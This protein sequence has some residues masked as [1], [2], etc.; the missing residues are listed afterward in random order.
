MRFTGLVAKIVAI[1]VF[2]TCTVFMPSPER[3]NALVGWVGAAGSP[4]IGSVASQP[5]DINVSN[6][7]GTSYIPHIVVDTNGYPCISWVDYSAGNEEIFF[8]RWNGS[9][10]I[11]TQGALLNATNGNVSNTPGRSYE[12]H[13]VL[14]KNNYP[15]LVWED[16]SLG[17]WEIFFSRWDGFQWVNVQGLPVTNTNRNVSNNIG[18][19]NIP[20]LVLDSL[21]NPCISWSDT[22]PGNH[23]IYY[24][25]WNGSNWVNIHGTILSSM[26]ANISNNNGFSY[27]SNFYLDSQDYPLITWYDDTVGNWEIF[28]CKWNGVNWVNIQDTILNSTNGNISNNIGRSQHPCVA[29]NKLNY[30]CLAWEDETS[31]PGVDEIYY[32]CFNGINW[33][34]AQSQIYN[35]INANISNNAGRSHHPSLVL[36]TLDFPNI[37]WSDNTSGNFEVYYSRFNGNNWITIDGY[38][39]NN[40]NPNISNTTDWSY[41]PRFTL[42]TLDNPNIVWADLTPGV[43]EIYYTKFS[44]SFDGSFTITKSVDTN[45]DGDYSDS[46]KNVSAGDT[47]SY[48]INWKFNQGQDALENPYLYDTIPD[49]TTYVSGSASPTANIS[50]STD[51]GATWIAGEPPN[52]SPAGTRLRWDLS[53][54]WVGAAG[55]PYVG[56]AATQPLDINVSRDNGNSQVPIVKRNSKGYPNI[57]W[58]D[59]SSG[60]YEIYFCKWNGSQWVNA[61]G[62]TFTLANGN[63]SNTAFD[64][65]FPDFSL[66][67][68][69][70]PVVAW[71]ELSSNYEIFVARWNGWLWTN[72]QG[73]PLTA[74]NGNVSNSTG[75][76]N[77][78]DLRIDKNGF[79]HLC[80]WDT[81]PGNQDIYYAKWDGSNW[82]NASNMI[83]T[84]TNPNVSNNPGV[85]HYP[86]LVL[87]SNN[88]PTI[89]WDDTSAGNR[90]I[91]FTRWNGS[92]W[93][94][95]NGSTLTATNANI[96]NNT[97]NSW[98]AMCILGSNDNPY[99]TWQDDTPGN[100]EIYFAKWNGGNWVDQNNV[101]LNATNANISNNVGFSGYA[102]LCLDSSS[103]PYVMW[104]DNTLGNYDIFFQKWNGSAWV[105][106]D[107]LLNSIV[108]IDISNNSGISSSPRFYLD[109]N[110]NPEL[111]WHDDTLGNNE[112][113]FVMVENALSF[114]FSVKIDN[115]AT[116]YGI[117]NHATFRHKWD[118]DSA[119]ESNE[120]CNTIK[121]NYTGT[122]TLEK[123][124]D[125]NGDGKYT[126]NATTIAPGTTLGYKLDWTFDNPNNDPLNGAYIYDTVPLGTK[127]VTGSSPTF[128]LS[129]STD[130]GFSW[131]AGEPPDGSAAGTILRWKLTQPGWTNA[132]GQLVNSTN[133]NMS[134]NTGISDFPSLAVYKDGHPS[135]AWSDDVLGTTMVYYAKWNGTQWVNAA[136]LPFTAANGN[137]A[138]LAGGDPSLALDP[139]TG[140]PWIAFQSNGIVFTNLEIHVVKWNGSQWTNSA[141]MPATLVNSNISNNAGLSW[142]PSQLVLDSKGYP[143]IVWKDNTTGSFQNYFARWNGTNWTNAAGTILNTTNGSMGNNVV[144]SFWPTISLDPNDRP[145]VAWD[146]NFGTNFE[147]YFA[148]WDGTQWVTA[149][150]TPLTPTNGNISNNTGSSQIPFLFTDRVT[151]NPCIAWSD[152]TPGNYEIYFARWNGS[153]WVN[154]DS[155]AIDSTN[156]NM[157]HTSGGSYLLSLGLDF[158]NLPAISWEDDTTG[159][160]EIYYSKWSGSA[161]VNAK[162]D[163]FTAV[164]GIINTSPARSWFPSLAFDPVT[165]NPNI[166]WLDKTPGNNEVYFA[167][168][169]EHHQTF[170]FSVIVDKP[171]SVP[172]LSPICNS[173]TFSHAFD[174]GNPLSSNSVCVKVKGASEVK[175]ANLVIRKTAKSL[176]YNPKDTFVF[177]ITVA[178]NGSTAAENVVLTDNFPNELVFDSSTPSGQVGFSTVKFSLGTLAPNASASFTLKFK[179]S[180]K[181]TI[182]DCITVINEAIASSGTLIVKDTA[183]INICT[184]KAPCELYI[185]TKWTNVIKGVRAKGEPVKLEV[186]PRCG[187]SPYS[188]T[189]DWGDGSTNS[190]TVEGEGESYITGHTFADTGDFTV[191]ITCVDA[192]GSTRIVTKTLY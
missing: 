13:L 54:L 38:T 88:Y 18:D 105:S 24:S 139:L 103:N 75:T 95:A 121:F 65:G 61:G 132:Q 150:G 48:K 192:Y 39:I 77:D 143:C 93:V 68:S 148:K 17:N 117:C 126:D 66:D 58:Q 44:N 32:L 19:S 53:S 21:G 49:G 40:L 9:T 92:S 112:I 29:K 63:V 52:G 119:I 98:Y 170:T 127:Y 71:S 87:D 164:N 163:A 64:S 155:T 145:F 97:G 102:A 140:N 147:V 154:S 47:L 100:S 90:E 23:E 124:V 161:W 51:G 111:V 172:A 25:K 94:N 86:D 67:S 142:F 1:V 116:S 129:Y 109:S 151:G 152:D 135:I 15:C 162:G 85:S 20:V 130:N 179:L 10:W 123:G 189:I 5:M 50:Y 91:F 79:V 133:P 22:T 176:Q 191:K 69:D 72:M 183:A 141:G 134:K 160:S 34:N 33:V 157:S 187:S 35:G 37:T 169:T 178:N 190:G 30:P 84:A 136:G 115:P 120:V 83:L 74:T 171:F 78:V 28:V 114:T 159:N 165:N 36:D 156:P 110:N 153:A 106:V 146:N 99:I 2:L 7:S 113:Y 46:G 108:N 184:P 166:A 4:Y 158:N 26:N 73:Q 11:N 27:D 8:A 107:N 41:S 128:N 101:A 6:N 173:A 89:V 185:D 62:S 104:N 31:T 168:W 181:T 45:N 138:G 182:D 81:T 186:I 144:N 149:S 42:D 70:N 60:N 59:N 56:S 137:V 82:V 55:S 16:N 131:L 174:G 12:H 180:P 57:V 175:G 14:D 76:S 80:W 122:F 118:N 177:Q 125:S 96:S 167:K 3:T 188:M 43:F